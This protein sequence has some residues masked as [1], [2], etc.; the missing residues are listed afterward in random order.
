LVDPGHGDLLVPDH[1]GHAGVQAGS[2]DAA[3]GEG[4]GQEERGRGKEAGRGADSH[5]D[6]FADFCSGGAIT[7]SM[8][9]RAHSSKATPE[10][11]LPP[12]TAVCGRGTRIVSDCVLTMLLG[13]IRI[14]RTTRES[15]S[16]TGANRTFLPAIVT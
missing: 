7:A 12:T 2:R 4:P 8:T 11:G 6:S 5:E 1:G 10:I 3:A 14:N 9:V 15:G 13:Y 16:E